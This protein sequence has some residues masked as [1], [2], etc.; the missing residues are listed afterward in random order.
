MTGY[1][2]EAAGLL[3]K[4]ANDNERDNYPSEATRLRLANEFAKLAMIEKGL[5]P[6]QSEAKGE[7]R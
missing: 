3:R 5:S 7:D 4:A 2:E 1:L 6:F